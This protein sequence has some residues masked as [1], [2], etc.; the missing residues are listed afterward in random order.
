MKIVGVTGTNGKTT[1]VHLICNLLKNYIKCASFGTLGIKQYIGHNCLETKTALTTLANNDLHYNLAKVE[2]NNCD[3]VAMEVSS[4]GLDQK[5]VNNVNFEIAVFTNLSQDHLDYH[6]TMEHYFHTKTKLFTEYGNNL[7]YAVINTDD[8]YGEKLIKILLNYNKNIKIIKFG[9]KDYCKTIEFGSFGIKALIIT[10]WGQGILNTKLLGQHNL[11][12]L[13]A[14]ICVCMCAYENLKLDPLLGYCSQLNPP[15]GRLQLVAGS[16]ADPKV[17][18]DY[19]HTPDG[20]EQVLLAIKQHYP[21]KKICCVFGCGGNRDV[22]KRPK[23]LEVADKHCNIVIL[24]QD[25]PRLE[26]PQKIIADILSYKTNKLL[27]AP[28]IELDRKLAIYKAI[29]HYYKDHIILIAGKGHEATQ[30]IGQQELPF[31]DK[32]VVEE[33]LNFKYLNI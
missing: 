27:I 25:N 15:A 2:N 1:V 21:N 31:C 20:L 9:I 26:D 18:I 33:A 17:I 4:H 12:N 10:P 19:A 29:K 28:I 8:L 14:S 11:S 22:T 24:T 5:R 6:K 16:L 13:L 3:L 32:Q 30:I 23:M 7:K